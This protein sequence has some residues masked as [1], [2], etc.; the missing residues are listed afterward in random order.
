MATPYPPQNPTPGNPY[1]PQDGYAPN[2]TPSAPYGAPN[3]AYGRQ[4]GHAQGP[5]GQQ[6][7]PQQQAYPQQAYGQQPYAPQPH[8]HQPGAGQAAAQ[9]YAPAPQGHTPG[10]A[11]ASG[12]VCRICGAGPAKNITVRQ[13]TGMVLAMRFSKMEGPLCRSCGVAIHRDMTTKTLAGGWWS[14]VSLV[15]FGWATLLWNLVVHFRLARLPQP[16]PSPTGVVMDQGKPIHQRP[17]AYVPI[18]LVVSWIALFIV[19]ASS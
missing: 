2:G 15:F 11:P 12:P 6:A 1:A 5:Y 16:T 19:N 8:G 3:A 10:Y 14:P 4:Q 7:H 13:H 17:L 18:L 9:G